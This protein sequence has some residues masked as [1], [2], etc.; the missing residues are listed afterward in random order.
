MPAVEKP[1]GPPFA[2]TAADQGGNS[3]SATGTLALALGDLDEIAVKAL[4]EEALAAERD[5][6]DI[7]QELQD[8]MEIVGKRFEADEYFL[9]ELIFA[10]EIFKQA[11]AP[12]GDSLRSATKG[13][14]GTMVL[15]TV[16]N[17][18]HDFGKDIVGMVLTS[19]GIKVVNLGV[20][21]EHQAVVDAIR[22]HKP[23]LV[24]LS[25]LL[26]TVFDDMKDTVAA[27]EAAG[28]RGQVKIMIGG[29]PVDQ[30]VADYVGADAYCVNAQVAVETA[31]RFLGGS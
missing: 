8:G 15:G 1:I 23:Q 12:L 25:C 30:S 11:N 3:L 2:R 6:L 10:A 28:M 19:N 24:G 21:V 9:S 4:V 31:K 13:T 17:D 5:P 29:G 14:L 20:N 16:K 27:I 22:E 18:I 7:V 26:T